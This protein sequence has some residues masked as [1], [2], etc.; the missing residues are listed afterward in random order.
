[1]KWYWKILIGLG[2]LII[3]I[4][5]VNIAANIW[6]K[7]QLPKIINSK[8]SAYYITYKNLEI[9][10][11]HSNIKINDIVLIPKAALKDTINKEGIYSKVDKVEIKNFKVLRFLFSDKLKAKS[12][13]V[14]T[15]KAVLYVRK[16]E[17]DIRKS[18]V[19]PFEKMITVSDVF[20][21]HGDF[22]MIRVKDSMAVLSVHNINL[23]VDGIIINDN[24]LKDKIPFEYSDYKFRCDSLYYHPNE[25]YHY[26]TK[27]IQTTKTDLRI[28]G[29]KMTPQYSRREFVSKIPKEKDLYTLSCDSI[30]ISNLDWGFNKD[31][32][33]VYCG[34]I[35]LEHAA[36]NIYRSL[37]PVDDKSKRRFYNTMLRDLKFDLRI[38]TLKVRNSI[39]EYEEEKSLEAGPA[40]LIFNPFNLT[41]TS[42]NSGFK[43]TKLPDLK[44]KI[45]CR[46]MNDCPLDVNWKLNVMDKKDGFNINGRLTNFNAENIIP[47]SKPYINVTTKGTIDEVRFNFN[48]NDNGSAGEF[49]VEYD[50]LKFTIYKKDD[51]KKKNKLATFIA[52]IFVKKDTNDKL[53][54]AHVSVMRIREKSFYNLLWRSIQEGLKKILV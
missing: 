30:N 24:I 52:K 50:D 54:S 8:D 26:Q 45:N 53:K 51:R 10:L 19:E 46:F 18:V 38:D 17:P 41:A 9:S 13:T 4:V 29:F 37:E 11:L 22:K 1:M 25:F 34:V 49:K 42:I 36:A 43:K 21:N 44:I 20:V 2:S 23:N 31:D 40:K 12:I 47:F 35:N 6:V 15:P 39:L 3:L 16:K 27:K 5:V 33:F 7:S 14:E 32:L 48:G 28:D